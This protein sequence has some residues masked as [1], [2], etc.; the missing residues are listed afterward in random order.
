VGDLANDWVIPD[1]LD[2][3]SYGWQLT[4][5]NSAIIGGA[6]NVQGPGTYSTTPGAFSL[7]TAVV[8]EP[9]S[10]FLLLAAAAA[11]LTRRAR[12]MI[13]PSLL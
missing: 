6:N 5:A 7:Q 8:P 9:G 2:G 13:R 12:R 4:D 3:N 1:P 11:H 10:A